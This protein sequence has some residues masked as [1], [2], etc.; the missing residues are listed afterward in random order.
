MMDVPDLVKQY[1]ETH[2]FM[3][4]AHFRTNDRRVRKGI[5]ISQSRVH[6]RRDARPP[7]ELIR[8]VRLPRVA[9]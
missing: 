1:D 4:D 5:A 8:E 7:V 2:P 3:V 6:L 9:N